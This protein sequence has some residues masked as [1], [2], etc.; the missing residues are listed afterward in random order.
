MANDGIERTMTPYLNN[1]QT[2]TGFQ[3]HRYR[4]TVDWS[5]IPPLVLA[6]FVALTSISPAITQGAVAVAKDGQQHLTTEQRVEALLKQMTVEEKIGQLNQSFHFVHSQAVDERIVSGAIGSI[7]HE[8]DTHEINRL[9]HLAVEK[10]R[11]HIPLIFEADVLHGY[12]IIFP[13][14]LGLAASW[15]LKMIERLHEGGALEARLS[16]Q[17]WTASPMLDI[18]RDPRW[19]RIVE[20]A[21]EDPFLGSKIAI[22]QVNGFQGPSPIDSQHLVA[23]LKHFAGYGES[24]GGR[25]H[26]AVYLSDPQLR[27]IVLKPFKAGVDAGA[28]TIMDAYIDLNDVPA[29]GNRWLLNDLLRDE[30]KFKGLVISDNNAVSDLV[31][32]GLARDLED[33]STRALHAGVDVFLSNNGTDTDGLLTAAKNRSLNIEELDHAVRRVLRLKFEMGL[34]DH[35]YFD[36]KQIDE[37]ILQAHLKAAREASNRSAVLLRNEGKLLPLH[38][39]TYRNVALIGPLADSRQD[40]VGPWTDGWMID[41]VVSVR[42]ALEESGKFQN[43][44]YAQGVQ[45]GRLFPSPFNR[46]LVEKP[47]DP[48]STE[49]AERQFQRAIEVA[50][51]SDLIIAVMGEQQLMS[52]ESA[53]R[54]SLDLPGRQEE[55]LKE[56]SKIGKPIVLVLLNGRPLTISWESEHIPGILEMWY[57]GTEGGNSVVDL[58]FGKVNP[59]GKIPITWPRNANQIPIYYSHNSTQDPQGQGTRYWDVPSTPLFPFGFGLSYTSFTFERPKVIRPTV[60]VGKEV[61]VEVNVT[62]CGDFAGEVVVQLYVH[63]RYGTAS[64]PIRELKG[65]ERLFLQ[66][67][68]NKVVR[69]V[70]L[71]TDLAYWSSSTKTWK[72]DASEFDV[73][74]GEDSTTTNGTT[75]AVKE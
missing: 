10:S 56:L 33:A 48:W 28:G 75:F 21:G 49:E 2:N 72:Q 66:P 25:D 22:A 31:P 41:R 71:P 55:L 14:P 30:W 43:V 20:G 70:V 52:G 6:A 64:R 36:E 74:V 5:S 57:P 8:F 40:T 24:E 45:L 69:F 54:A 15:D 67:H 39:G 7:D 11:L 47:Q 63:Q 26:D 23:A 53:S 60:K 46:K 27:N 50:K 42:K 44:Q 61:N 19:G 29:S 59:A 3:P 51:S 4:K 65:F 13:V 62:N 73:W 1:Q 9:Q 38:E 35:P 18:T 34:F 16:G 37:D 12:R 17:Q 68:E 58:L 32:H